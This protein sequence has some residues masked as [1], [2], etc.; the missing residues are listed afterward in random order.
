MSQPTYFFIILTLWFIAN[1]AMLIALAI[2]VMKFNKR[3]R[4]TTPNPSR[5]GE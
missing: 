5:G 1:L 2:S 3:K 4:E